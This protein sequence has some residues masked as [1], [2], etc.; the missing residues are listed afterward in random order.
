MN[1]EELVFEELSLLGKKPVFLPKELEKL[2]P[3][4]LKVSG[5]HA[6]PKALIPSWRRNSKF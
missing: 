5:N 4:R 3:E 2:H 6:L 1:L